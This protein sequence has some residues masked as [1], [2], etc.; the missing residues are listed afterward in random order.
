M[1]RLSNSKAS[2]IQGLNSSKRVK[3]YFKVSIIQGLIS[4][5]GL[6]ANGF[7]RNLRISARER[8]EKTLLLI[9]PLPLVAIGTQKD[10]QS[11]WKHLHTPLDDSRY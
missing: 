5:K 3:D 8:M 4:V 9:L 11:R 6:K 1:L 2:L 10:Y 7:F